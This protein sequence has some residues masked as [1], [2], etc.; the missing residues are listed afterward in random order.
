MFFWI[1]ANFLTPYTKSYIGIL[2]HFKFI[3]VSTCYKNRFR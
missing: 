2:Q 1:F 3:E